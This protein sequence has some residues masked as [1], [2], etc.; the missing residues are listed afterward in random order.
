MNCF[1]FIF[2]KKKLASCGIDQDSTIAIWDWKKGKCLARTTMH[3]E[4]VFDLQFDV[5]KENALVS[6]GV[7]HISFWTL[8]GNTFKKKKGIFGQIKDMQTM[9]CLSASKTN[10]KYYA[11]TLS[12]SIY[13]WKNT[14]L[15]EIIPNVHDGAIYAIC[16]FVD[17]FLTGGKDG[18][19]KFWDSNFGALNEMTIQIKEKLKTNDD[20]I[21]RSLYWNSDRILIGTQ[22]SE[23]YEILMNDQDNPQCVTQG[24][25]EGE[26]WSLAVSPTNPWIFATASDDKTVRIWD[27]K[28]N[29]MLKMKK[30]QSRIRSCSFSADSKQ[31][32]CGLKNG[33]LVVLNVDNMSEIL[34]AKLRNEVLHEMKYSPCGR[35]LAVGSNDNFVDVLDTQEYKKL[36]TCS[37][38]SSF[39]TH[40]DWTQDSQY[41]RTN[42]G[43][44]ECDNLVFKIPNCKQVT[45]DEEK[46]IA[47]W[48]TFTGVL[49]NEVVGIW[50]KYSNKTDINATDAYFDAQCIV[51]GDDFGLIKLFRF[52]SL[53]KGAKFRKYCGHSSHVTNVRFNLDHTRVISVGGADH[54]IFQWRF[55]PEDLVESLQSTSREPEV[56]NNDQQVSSRIEEVQADLPEE[57]DAY[58]D[59]N[60]EDSDSDKSGIEIDSD[61]ERE[62]EENYSKQVYKDDLIALKP[63]IKKE[64]KK[65][66]T[67]LRE[68]RKPCPTASISIKHVIGYRGYDCRDNL[69]FLKGQDEIIYHVAAL[70]IVYNRETN[71]Q[72]FYNGHSDDILCL[73]LHP[74]KE[75]DSK[76]AKKRKIL[77]ATG[78]I[79]R[80]PEIHVWDAVSMNTESILKGEHFRGVCALSFS[81]DG[82]KLASVGLDDNHSICVWD[83]KKGEKLAT[84]RGHKDK[85]FCIKW[86]PYDSDK[87]L[88]IG[89]KHIKFWSQAGGGFTSHRGLFGTLSKVENI[90]CATYGKDGQ[91]CYTGVGNGNV[92]VWRDQKLVKKIEAHKGP[93]NAIYAL[94]GLSGFVTGGKDGQVILWSEEFGS[95]LKK[96][97]LSNKDSNLVLLEDN[98]SI[99]SICLGFKKIL[100][101]TKNSEIIEIDKGGNM[102]VL[103]QGHAEGELWGLSCHPRKPE[104]C[105]TS[106]DKTVRIWD[107]NTF[108][109]KL[110]KKLTDLGRSCEY[111]PDGSLIAV[112]TKNGTVFIFDEQLE[113]VKTFRN[114]HKEISD[115]KFSPPMNGEFKYLAVGSHDDYVDIYH[116]NNK[117]RIGICKGS[118]SYISHID[119]DAEGHI[120]MVNT[121]ARELL[122]YEAP[123]GN[124]VT[125]NTNEVFGG[126]IDW[127]SI[128]GVLGK[129][130]E[131]IWPP[132]TD[133]TDINSTHLSKNGKILATG[134]DFGLVK[135]F[136]YPC[137]GK[138]SK[139]KRYTGHS[140][141]IT[142]VR[143]TNEDRNLISV[144]GNDMSIIIW[145][146]QVEYTNDE[147]KS[148]VSANANKIVNH[149]LGESEDSDTDS[150]D[151]GYDSD[152]K[153][154]QAIDY[155]KSIFQNVIKRPKAD[156]IQGLYDAKSIEKKIPSRE[157]GRLKTTRVKK[158]GKEEN[159]VDPFLM[160]RFMSSI[161]AADQLATDS[162]LKMRDRDK[163]EGL[164]LNYIHG[165]RGTDCRDNLHYI[166][167]GSKIVYCAAGAGIVLDL[168][169]KAQE[170]Y[171]EHTDDIISLT[172]NLNKNFK[173]IV[174]TGQVGTKPDIHIWHALTRETLSILSGLHEN[175]VMSLNFSSSGKFLVS[176]GLDSHYTIGVWRW[177]E[178][179]LVASHQGDSLGYRVFRAAYRPDSDTLFVSVGFKH[180]K[181]WN[182]AGSQLVCKKGVLTDQ[183][184]KAKKLPTMLSIG[185]GLDLVTYTGSGNGD[186]FVWKENIL[187]KIIQN[188][189][190]GPIF[191]IYTTITDGCIVTGG[192]E[193][194]TK[195]SCEIKLW[196]KDMNSSKSFSLN[197]KELNVIKSV[198]RIKNRILVGTKAGEIYEIHDKPSKSNYDVQ[199]LMTGHSYGA[200]WGLSVHPNLDVFATVSYDGYLKVWDIR[201][202]A[203]LGTH[204]IGLPI[205]SCDF[206]SDGKY[207]AL[208]LKDG[209]IIIV[210]CTERFDCF[211]ITEKKRQRDSCITD[212]KFNPDDKIISVG[213]DDTSIDFYEFNKKTG[214]LSRTGYCSQVPG[215]VVQ[216]DWSNDSKY[217][218][219]GTSD[220]KNTVYMVPQGNE[221]KDKKIIELVVWNEWSR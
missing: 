15:E 133:V 30:L 47:N 26:L 204:K 130:L 195:D 129:T 207:L 114:R 99:K 112:G 42:S 126:T 55:I 198:C 58:M 63:K 1:N 108:K 53:K 113:E 120:L 40:L 35:Y 178:G 18:D 132:Y 117:K 9:V 101:G 171:L 208:G 56:V 90:L 28:K 107:M 139:F 52:P 32:A 182:V 140:S 41:I 200:I 8:I 88:T 66:E 81:S 23:I 169:T 191:T 61:I 93:L 4:K 192:K 5:F 89:I 105:T 161:L 138:F 16:S 160:L 147:N 122:F 164:K 34:C 104:F 109:L 180:I 29:R 91:T 205:H 146:N 203:L 25:A 74:N 219:V 173:N 95:I 168:A 177:K 49:G 22:S 51:T 27:M 14:Q 216:I 45:G 6:C 119:W 202:K 62:K 11:G 184:Q 57:Y 106:D 43:A 84:T 92:Y 103:I 83:W 68:K 80:D 209:E 69:F 149:H 3:Q 20:F 166:E 213:H 124:R 38:S 186:I 102:N 94:D 163:I 123:R 77:A 75:Y 31:L 50:E 73:C 82:K 154:E 19:I 175:G 67:D 190:K 179:S 116:V 115:I 24:H 212:I 78:Q 181:F 162:Q 170:Y 218:R 187:I 197:N 64:I 193:K 97:N 156:V 135:L 217:I 100:V 165:Y 48:A 118:S 65:A 194:S 159:K 141:H 60:S 110:S 46:S 127:F 10:E 153:R 155:V 111:S 144:G 13:V 183:G 220:C 21:I 174:A 211:K 79:G 86:N 199:K 12:G 33:I 7:K 76:D 150:E 2:Y 185:F 137:N 188:A 206:N 151:E 72:R 59:S 17:G 85:I 71:T 176:I 214:K 201:T 142:R 189:H 96:F 54:A 70:G 128:S 143:W 172:V 196:D 87:L 125:I 167:D 136:N 44:G 121:G 98:P 221:V 37:G 158:V 134:D 148:Q 215:S 131:G 145:E 210:E 39:I 36:G 152:V 157:M